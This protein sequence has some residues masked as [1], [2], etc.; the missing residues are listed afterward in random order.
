MWGYRSSYSLGSCHLQ[1]QTKCTYPPNRTTLPT[2]TNPSP[3]SSRNITCQYRDKPDGK[4]CYKLHG[5]PN[6][7]PSAH[8]C[9][10]QPSVVGSNWILDSGATHHITYNLNQLHLTQPYHGTDHIAIG[11][12]NTVPIVQTGKYVLATKTHQ[13]HLA[14]VLHVPHIY[15]KCVMC[16]NLVSYLALSHWI[17]FWF[18]FLCVKDL[19]T[20]DPLLKGLLNMN[21]ITY[22]I[23][24]FIPRPL[25]PWHHIVGHPSHKIM[26]HLTS[27]AGHGWF[28]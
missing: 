16:F 17:F 3:Q 19:K 21:S 10:L 20:R 28:F 24:S 15:K 27:R 25:L 1:R 4:V 8:K 7:C 18:L 26:R 13:L 9:A 2:H 23:K 22:P 6:R 14:E 11:D 5:Y 12:G